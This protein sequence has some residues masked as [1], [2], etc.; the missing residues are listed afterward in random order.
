[1]L[2]ALSHA[3]DGAYDW[4]VIE[5]ASDPVDEGLVNFQDINWKLLKIAQ[6]CAEG[7]GYLFSRPL[8]AAQF[9]QLLQIGIA[10]TIVH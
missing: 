8:A 3:N 2:E 7:Q 10:E 4:R 6:T 1:V 5:I 9:A